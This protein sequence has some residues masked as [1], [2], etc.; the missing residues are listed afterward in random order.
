MDEKI[1]NIIAIV[2]LSEYPADYRYVEILENFYL[3]GDFI[4]EELIEYYLFVKLYIYYRIM[5][6]YLFEEREG[7]SENMRL[8]KNLK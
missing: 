5:K 4:T 7:F 1:N 8:I 2:S 6:E 3:V